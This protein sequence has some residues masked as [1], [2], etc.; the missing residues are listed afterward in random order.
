MT[1]NAD[2]LTSALLAAAGAGTSSR[3]TDSGT[4]QSQRKN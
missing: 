4:R 2:T 1:V 3:V